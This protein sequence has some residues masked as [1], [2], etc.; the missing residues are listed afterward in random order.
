MWLNGRTQGSKIWRPRF[1]L[2]FPK[3]L[4]F[5]V[6][7]YMAYPNL[8]SRLAHGPPSIMRSDS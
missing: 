3:S 4:Q 5:K 6:A 1:N 8:S 2:Q 7:L